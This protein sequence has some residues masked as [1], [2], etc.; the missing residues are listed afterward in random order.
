[1]NHKIFTLIAFLVL[2]LMAL[3]RQVSNVQAYQEGKTIVITYDLDEAAMIDLY[4]VYGEGLKQRRE[5]TYFI[6]DHSLSG[7]HSPNVKGDVGYVK[8]GKGKRIVWDV[9]Q[10]QEKFIHKKVRFKVDAKSLYSGNKTI[11]LAEYGYGFAPQ[12]SFGLTIGQV[13]RS[14]GW[15]A[16]VRTNFS[17]MRGSDFVCEE[18]GYIDGMLPFYSGVTKNNHIVANVGVV[19]DLFGSFVTSGLE[20]R[21]MLALYLGLG[22]GQRYQ[23]WET[24]DH[25]WITY[26]PTAFKGFSGELGLMASIKGFTIMAGV[27]T[28]NFKYLEIEAG[29]GWTIPHKNR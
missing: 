3:A 5:E 22:Y 17:A 27:N 29:L 26:G 28:I 11:L 23:L 25:K 14:A 19:W 2:P 4:V 21:S 16:S 1:M 7:Y 18:G 6:Y 15:Y 24:I 20:D 9:L 12:H 10:E 13:Y 8:A